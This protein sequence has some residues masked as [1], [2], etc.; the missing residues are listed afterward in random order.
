MH[1]CSSVGI[2]RPPDSGGE[3]ITSIQ[4]FQPNE[5]LSEELLTR[6]SYVRG[7]AYDR[8]LRAHCAGFCRSV[9]PSIIVSV[10]LAGGI[11]CST[12]AVG[13]PNDV[14]LCQHYQITL[15]ITDVDRI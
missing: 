9:R 11:Y 4:D 14:S 1:H 15:T 8:H 5:L 12:A 2:M 10:S 13:R 7:G 6:R 3:I